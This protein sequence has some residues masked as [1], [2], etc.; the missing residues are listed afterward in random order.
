MPETLSGVTVLGLGLMLG[1]KHALDADHLVA[2]STFLSKRHTFLNSLLIGSFWGI[3]HSLS[4]LAVGILV[5]LFDINLPPRVAAFLEFSVALMLI[6]LGLS[7]LVR[8][9]RGGHLHTHWHSHGDRLHSHPHLHSETETETP[10][11]HHGLRPGWKPLA[12]GMVH[13]L[14]GSAALMLIVLSTIESRAV[15]LGYI[16]VFGI[17]SIGGMAMMSSIVGLPLRLTIRRFAR[18]HLVIQTLAGF[19][20]LGFGLFLAFELGVG[21]TR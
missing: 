21:W 8:V 1:L 6:G 2:V 20:S 12:V 14:A 7:A 13:G 15:A 9:I 3:G 17:G 18:A 10:H 16:F 11:S 4:L 19:L 5:V